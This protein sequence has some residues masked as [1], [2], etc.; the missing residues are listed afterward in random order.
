MPPSVPQ[1]APRIE[2]KHAAAACP[3]L[4]QTP[5]TSASS[6]GSCRIGLNQPGAR[7]ALK[8]FVVLNTGNEAGSSVMLVQRP[9]AVAV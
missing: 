8:V 4:P 2:S 3:P 6:N 1:P 7:V 5:F 9:L